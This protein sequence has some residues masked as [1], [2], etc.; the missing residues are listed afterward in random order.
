MKSRSCLVVN[1]NRVESR[2][3]RSNG[4]IISIRGNN[5]LFRHCSRT[6]LHHQFP[7]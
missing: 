4:S 3:L 6:Q 5:G 2:R 1:W 7:R